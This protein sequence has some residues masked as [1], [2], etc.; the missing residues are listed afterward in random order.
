[1]FAGFI[2]MC[3][4]LVLEPDS[5]NVIVNS[6]VQFSCTGTGD[7]ILFLVNNMTINNFASEGFKQTQEQDM[8]DGGVI[9]RNMTLTSATTDLNNTEIQCLIEDTQ[10]SEFNQS[11]KA[12]IR[13]QGIEYT[14]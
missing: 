11:D 10:L 6:P 14:V 3:H 13:V 2:Q 4:N 5:I 12:I 8:L 9:R 7:S 1:M